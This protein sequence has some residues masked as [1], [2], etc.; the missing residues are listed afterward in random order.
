MEDRT[1]TRQPRSSRDQFVMGLQFA[2][3]LLM[4]QQVA[5]K[6]ARDGLFLLY[7]GPQAL[8]PMV[9]GAAGFWVVLS[10][11]TGRVMHRLAPR[12]VVPWA[13]GLSGALLVAE[14][15]LLGVNPG[16]ASVV[17]YLHMAGVGLVLLSSFWSMLNE[18]FD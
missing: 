10:L 4:A 5:G 6:A 1:Q 8:P 2:A 12:V 16:I 17:I 11:L 15:W 3:A 13:L 7:H 14:G 18:E 9:A